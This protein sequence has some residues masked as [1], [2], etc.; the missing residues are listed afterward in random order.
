MGGAIIWDVIFGSLATLIGAALGYV[1]RR[2]RWLVPIPTVIANTV[3]VPVVLKYA[4]GVPLP[5]PLIALYVLIGE[6]A[7]CYVLGE[8]LAQ[9]LLKYGRDLFRK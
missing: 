5:L 6:I 4:Y 1:L 9:I 7:G 2:N 8:V 3:I